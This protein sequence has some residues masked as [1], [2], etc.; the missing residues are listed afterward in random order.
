MFY[1]NDLKPGPLTKLIID[2]LEDPAKPE[3]DVEIGDGE[4]EIQPKYYTNSLAVDGDGELYMV[5]QQGIGIEGSGSVFNLKFKQQ[6][7]VTATVN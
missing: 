7:K 2:N 1:R 4:E 6:V 3:R 5:G